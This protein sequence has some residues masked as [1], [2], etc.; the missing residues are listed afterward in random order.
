V[1]DA[2]VGNFLTDNAIQLDVWEGLVEAGWEHI[3]DDE[4]DTP[5]NQQ[6]L[7]ELLDEWLTPAE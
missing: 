1:S 4:F 7:P 2:A 3:I 6:N 5:G